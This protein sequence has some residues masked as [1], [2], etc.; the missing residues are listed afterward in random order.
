MFF[1]DFVYFAGFNRST[2]IIEIIELDLYDLDFRILCQDLIQDSSLI[3]EGNTDMSD[4]DRK[5]VV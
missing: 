5:S 3:M 4:L 1:T 2:F